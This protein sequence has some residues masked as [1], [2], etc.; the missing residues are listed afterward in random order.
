VRDRRK[1]VR[2]R[3]LPARRVYQDSRTPVTA[4]KPFSR[5]IAICLLAV[6]L[7]GYVVTRAGVRYARGEGGFK[8]GVDLAGGTILVYEVDTEKLAEESKDPNRKPFDPAE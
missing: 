7:A 2:S 3:T 8:L 4:M 5:R 6:L 1:T